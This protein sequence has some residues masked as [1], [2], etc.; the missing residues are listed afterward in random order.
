MKDFTTL[1][2][3]H[4]Q[5]KDAVFRTIE[6]PDDSTVRFTLAIQDDWGEDTHEVTVELTGVTDSRLLQNSMLGFLDMMSGA[7]VVFERN[8]YGFAI[9]NC[10]AML[11]VKS[12]PMYAIGADINIEEKAL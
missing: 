2:E 7:S 4:D 3:K 1:L 5:F 11:C 6:V 12:A 9:G 10:S 8:L